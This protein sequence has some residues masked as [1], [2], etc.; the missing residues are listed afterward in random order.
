M[1]D[2]EMEVDKGGDG[3]AGPS[4]KAKGPKNG[5]RFEIKKWSAVAMWSWAVGGTR[6]L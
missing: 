3:E 1:S 4:S 5:K 2:N 6:R